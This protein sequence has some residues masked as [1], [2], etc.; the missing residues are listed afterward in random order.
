MPDPTGRVEVKGT[1]DPGTTIKLYADGGTTVIGTGTVDSTGHYDIY[2]QR[3]D[4]RRLAQHHGDRKHARRH[5]KPG[6]GGGKRRY[7]PVANTWTITSATDL[8]KAIAA[9][10]VSGSS[11]QAGAHYI[12]NIVSDLKLT[13]QLPAFNLPQG[14][15]LDHQ[16]Q[17]PHPRCPRPAGPVRLCGQGRDRRPQRRQCRGATAASSSFYGGGGAGLGGGLFIAS[18]GQVTLSDVNFANDQACRRQQQRL[19]VYIAAAW[20]RWRPQGGAGGFTGGGGIGIHADGAGNHYLYQAHTPAGTGIVLG[21]AS[22]GSRTGDLNSPVYL[23]GANG[24]GG[25][26]GTGFYTSSNGYWGIAGYGRPGSGGG[27]GGAAGTATVGGRRLWWGWRRRR[28]VYPGPG[29]GGNGGFGGGGGA[30]GPQR[31]QRRLRRR[32]RWLRL[33]Q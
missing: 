2:S 15:S 31:R 5:R 33:Q 22:G 11:A 14:A 21:A 23:G 27:I 20:R 32:R 4:Q 13:D 9:I 16:G 8:A 1:G 12:F 17:Q 24:G 28:L 30:G 6:L 3:I 29:S 19:H 18:A 7:V 10:D 25:G 26:Q